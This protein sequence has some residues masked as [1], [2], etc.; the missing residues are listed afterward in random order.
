M[1][2]EWNAFVEKQQRVTSKMR[3]I[4]K[5]LKQVKGENDKKKREALRKKIHNMIVSY[6]KL[7]IARRHAW[8]DFLL[9]ALPF[10]K[11]IS[12][13]RQHITHREKYS[14][15]RTK[16]HTADEKKRSIWP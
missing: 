15:F 14:L 12:N 5:I 4:E 3:A 16:Q 13:L 2:W 11:A 10:E 6:N 7:H 9:V 8:N 1:E